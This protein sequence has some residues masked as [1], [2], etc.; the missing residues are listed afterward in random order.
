[1]A[2]LG[3]AQSCIDDLSDNYYLLVDIF[4]SSFIYEDIKTIQ[5]PCENIHVIT[6]L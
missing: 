5:E 2:K 3:M 4:F 1:M 6:W